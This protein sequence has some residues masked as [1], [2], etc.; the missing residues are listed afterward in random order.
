MGFLNQKFK[1]TRP[2]KLEKNYITTNDGLIEA[3]I[4]TINDFARNHTKVHHILR[5]FT[6]GI[7][8]ETA[9]YRLL[10]GQLAFKSMD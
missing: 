1:Y 2:G 4:R 9:N 6:H 10:T 3:T 5:K 8:V 7:N